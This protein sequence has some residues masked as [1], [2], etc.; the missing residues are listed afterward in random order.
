MAKKKSAAPKHVE[1]EDESQESPEEEPE[2]EETDSTSSHGKAISK[3]E[4]I[5]RV[6]A[7]GIDNPSVG[8]QEIKKRFGIDVTP[9]HF[10]ATKAQMKSKQ[11]GPKGK[12][13]RKPKGATS[14]AVE[15]YLAPP[16]KPAPA[17]GSE[18]L[19]AMEA[20]KPLVASLGKEQVKR[21]VD[22]LG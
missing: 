5:R 1:P 8:S 16:P 11:G 21:I 9:Q 15:G 6:I 4:A 22:L 12:P 2:T 17:G 7:D 3:A 13:G 10:S 19:D 18:L 14:Q 20:M